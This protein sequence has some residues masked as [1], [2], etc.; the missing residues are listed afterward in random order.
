MAQ[1]SD[2]DRDAIDALVDRWR[3]EC[4]I[5]DG[6]LIFDGETV[7]SLENFE[8]FYRAYNDRIDR[9]EGS[10]DEK[11]EAQVG[12]QPGTV[13][14]L[15]AEVIAI[16]FLFASQNTVGAAR[17]RELIGLVLAWNGD[18]LAE[19]G[20][21]HAAMGQAIGGPGQAYNNLRWKHIAYLVSLFR[22]FK[23][24]SAERRAEL[25][26]DA[27]A[28]KAWIAEDD[29]DGGEQMMRHILLHLL[30]PH[31]YERIASG[32]HK[33][34]IAEHLWG[35]IE[36]VPLD[37]G[38]TG[39]EED[40]DR[41]LLAI[42]QRIEKLRDDGDVEL[43]RPLDFYEGLLKRVWDPPLA[44]DESA[45]GLT[46]LAA[47]EL[48]R[49]VVLFGPPGTGK[50]HEAKALAARLLHAAALDRWKAVAYLKNYRRVDAI[51]ARQVRRLQLHQAYSYEDFIRGL[52]LTQGGAT[53]PVDGY[54]L[55]L[56]REIGEAP[57]SPD[58]L[59]PLP[60]VLV[61]DE[62]NRTDVSR[63]FGEAF[64]L[65]EDRS[66]AI[67]LPMLGEEGKPRSVSLPED[68]YVIGT[69]NLIDQSVEQLDFALR[70]RFLWI[71]SGFSRDAIIDV[72]YERW[73]QSKYCKH[74]GWDRIEGEIDLLAER[75]AM[76]NKDIATS[77]LLGEQYEIGHT[78][79]FDIV[80]FLERWDDLR[81]RGQRPKGYLWSGAGHPKPPLLDL[82]EHSLRPL[83]HEYLAGVD[84]Q[85][86]QK[87]LT[88]LRS[89]LLAGKR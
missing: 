3:S 58:G 75:A 9:G 21:V 43:D 49:Q 39:E 41:A 13:T 31:E 81:L 44:D 78:Y 20:D 1:Y 18:T 29:R 38:I 14:R 82:W 11:F 15:A 26:A 84:A 89:V 86:R 80:G 2:T 69:M 67:D 47:L 65:L 88:A 52:R 40:V 72:V 63:L 7:W 16:Y 28:F 77:R 22:E 30:F 68:L 54:L 66:A 61:L 87:E 33:Y 56:C 57:A 74:H 25:V 23:R 60:W 36:E 10:F 37:D 85:A 46:N 73:Q 62:L 70:R 4:L 42:R 5:E 83:L 12:D 6:S 34:R 45:G 51:G 19:S 79:F 24:L 8:L 76:L 64:S 48:K 17:K 55:E 71:R 53:T 27:W 50:T 59:A 32:P 35:L